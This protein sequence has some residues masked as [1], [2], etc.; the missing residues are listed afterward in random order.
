[1]FRNSFLKAILI[2]E[3]TDDGDSYITLKETINSN[4]FDAL[5]SNDDAIDQ[6]F[7]FL[8]SNKIRV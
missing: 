1:M 5:K 4:D 8:R 6:L 2:Q 7:G 3:D